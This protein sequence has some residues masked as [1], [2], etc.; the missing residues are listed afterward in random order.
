MRLRTIAPLRRSCTSRARY[1][2]EP[3]EERT[4]LATFVVTRADVDGVNGSLR[5]AILDAN[6]NPGPDVIRFN[7]PGGGVHTIQT[8]RQL[9][10][11]TSPVEVDGTSQPGWA[12][13]HPVIELDGSL[14]S[15]GHGLEVKV[16]GNTV[17]G[18]IIHNYPWHGMVFVEA[19]SLNPLGHNVIQGNFIGT[20]ATGAVARGNGFH[21]LLFIDS[22]SNT[23]GGTVVGDGNLISGNH[24]SGISFSN[25]ISAGNYIVGNRIGTDISG[26]LPLGNQHDG[27]FFSRQVDTNG[28]GYASGN[29]IGSPRTGP[30][31]VLETGG[32][33]IAGNK[34]NGIYILKGSGN[35]VQNN[36]I[37]V[38]ADG[39][40]IPNGTGAPDA[41]VFDGNGVLIE[42]A[43]S[44]VIG[45]VEPGSG[46]VISG[47]RRNGVQILAAEVNASFNRVVGNLIGTNA[48]GE[49]APLMGNRAN[50][51]EITTTGLEQFVF[52]LGNS[53]GGADVSDGDLDE[54]VLARNVISGNLHYG[55]RVAGRVLST[56]IEGNYVGTNK[57]GEGFVHNGFGGIGVVGG[58][59]GASV[60]SNTQIGSGRPGGGNVLSGNAGFG[61]HIVGSATRTFVFGNRIGTNPR[62]D[63]AL[64]N[65]ID[66]SGVYIDGSSDNVIGGTGEGEGNVIS[67]NEG[68]G[69]TI[70][71]DS[72]NNAIQ[73]SLIGVGADGV[74][75]LPNLHGITIGSVEGGT[76]S[77]TGNW[78]GGTEA[79]VDG[80]E[81]TLGN[82]IAANR[83]NG[84]RILA[85]V[86][87]TQ[88]IGNAIGTNF[89]S[90]VLGNTDIGVLI[91]RSGLNTVGGDTSVAG[92]LIAY[93]GVAGVVVSGAD[94][95][96]NKLFGNGIA[97]NG[98]RE[99][100]TG[101]SG[102]RI[103]SGAGFTTVDGNRIR[104]NRGDGV[105]ISRGS[106]NTLTRN[107]IGTEEDG[108]AGYGVLIDESP[109]N[110]IGDI[111]TVDGTTTFLGNSISGN[112]KV[113]V[114]INGE[115]STGNRVFGNVITS[116]GDFGIDL[117]LGPSSTTVNQ[118]QVYN[119][120]SGG[121]LINESGPNTLTNN[122][123][124]T[125]S[126]GAEA[127]PNDGPGVWIVSSPGIV[128]GGADY[129]HG[130]NLIS[131]NKSIGIVV[132]GGKTIGTVITGNYIGVDSTATKPLGNQDG[133]GIGGSEAVGGAA[134]LTTVQ[135][136][137]I[138]GNRENGVS[139]VAGASANHLL[140]NF[141]GTNADDQKGLGNSGYGVLIKGSPLN[142]VGG[143]N[144]TDGNDIAYNGTPGATELSAGVRI[145]GAASVGNGL[146]GNTI[147]DNEL[148]AVDITEGAS[149]TVLDGNAIYRNN[150]PG[151]F[152][153]E[154]GENNRLINNLI[155]TDFEGLKALP[156]TKQGVNVLDTPGTIIGSASFE[157][158]NVISGNDAAGI[159]LQGKLTTGTR[160][161]GNIIGLDANNE[162]DLPNDQGIIVGG[163]TADVAAG[164][165]VIQNNVIAGNRSQGVLITA[166]STGN[167]IGGTKADEENLIHGNGGLGIDLGDDGVTPNDGRKDKD[168]GSNDLQNYPE[169]TFAT[170]NGSHRVAGKLESDPGTKYVLELF[171]NSEA[172]PSKFGEGVR[173]LARTEVTT[174]ASGIA[175][176]DITLPATE[177]PDS[178]VTATATN[179][180]RGNT[181]EFSKAVRIQIDSDGDGVP[182]AVENA[183]PHAGDFNQDGVKDGLQNKAAT[184]PTATTNE[185]IL[186]QLGS[187]VLG[188]PAQ[189]GQVLSNVRPLPNPSPDD[190][191]SGV[192]FHLG[193]FDFSITGL[194]LGG[195]TM[196]EV[197]LPPGWE[198]SS[199]YRYGPT[200]DQPAPHWYDWSFDGNT[201]AQLFGN[202][203]VLRFVDGQR[204]DDDLVANGTIVD[205]G[206]A[207]FA[208]PIVVTN[209]LDSG[210]G[211]L[212]RAIEDAN[213]R[214]GR[215]FIGFD[216]GTG[217]QTI[218]TLSN[219]PGIT[220]PVFIDGTSQP[221][222]NG[223]P[224]IEINGERVPQ[225]TGLTISAPFTTVRGLVI[226]RFVDTFSGGGIGIDVAVPFN[227]QSGVV[228][229]GNFIG[230]DVT[231]MLRRQN[232]AG[233]VVRGGSD[234]RIGGTTPESR[235]VVSGNIDNGIEILGGSGHRVQGNFV[236]VAANGVSP[237]E[238]LEN[239]VFVGDTFRVTIG[240]LDQAAGNVIAFNRGA[241][242][243]NP[244]ARGNRR[245]T[246]LSNSIH[247]N[248]LLGIARDIGSAG[249]VI[250]ND[251]GTTDGLLT[252][253][254]NYPVLWSA[255]S[256]DDQT[257]ISGYFNSRPDT[258]FLLQFFSNSAVE[259]SGFG[260]GRT[261][262]GTAMVHTNAT[263]HVDFT[264][265]F[266]GAIARG[267]LVTATSTLSLFETTALG[268]TSEFSRRLV[269]G[270]VLAQVITVNSADDVDDGVADA[271]H[272]SLREAIH[273]ANNFP[274][275]N[276]IRFAIGSGART[277]RPLTP[278][279][280]ITDAVLIDG[281]TQPGFAGSPVIQLTGLGAP[282]ASG[283]R[284]TAS[285][286]T[287]RGL[288]IN[289]FR[290][291]AGIEV[292]EIAAT[293]LGSSLPRVP[294]LHDVVIEGNFIGTSADG[295]SAQI[296]TGGNSATSSGNG[297][298]IFI[299]GGFDHL[300]GGTTPAARNVISANLADGI[301][302]SSGTRYQVKGSLIGVAA[303]GVS[304]LGNGANGV[305]IGIQTSGPNFDTRV[306]QST[307]GGL[308]SGAGNVIAFNAFHGVQNRQSTRGIAV[309]SNSIH[310]NALMGV[311]AGGIRSIGYPLS[312][313]VTL[314]DSGLTDGTDNPQNYP[315]L[316]SAQ[317][318]GDQTTISGSLISR[319]NATFV[320]QF[321]SNTSVEVSGFGEGET[322]LGSET[323]T[324]GAAGHV[325]FSAVLPVAVA[326]RRVITATATG[327][328]NNT[329]EFSR[330]LAVGD[331]LSGVYTVNTTD[332]VD[333]GT[334]DATHTSLREAIHA[335]NNHPGPD[336]I[337]FAIGSGVRT[338]SPLT[339]LPAIVDPQTSI[340]GT[341]QPGYA[342]APVIELNGTLMERGRYDRPS[343]TEFYMTGLSIRTDE[344]TIRGLVMNR[345]FE[346]TL[347][348]AAVVE[349]GGIALDVAGNRNVIEGN[350]IGT[351]VAGGGLT[352]TGTGGSTVGNRNILIPVTVI[353]ANNRV[354]GTTPQQRNVISGH[355]DVGLKVG[356]T[357]NLIQG[358]YIGTNAA[359]TAAIGNGRGTLFD[360]VGVIAGGEG[361]MIGGAAPGAGN[362]ISG[363]SGHGLRAGVGSVV[364]GN[365][366]GTNAAGTARLGNTGD[367]I[368]IDDIVARPPGV[369][370]VVVGG[371]LPGERNVISGN[372]NGIFIASESFNLIQGNY[373]GT[374]VTGIADL[375]NSSD[376]IVIARGVRQQIGG[377]APGAGNLISGNDRFGILVA[378]PNTGPGH[379]IQGNRVGTQANGTSALG[380]S[381]DGIMFA[382]DLNLST[383]GTGPS[384]CIV[385]GTEEGA[386][387]VIA[388]NGRH[389]VNILAGSRIGIL[390]NSIHSN[391][392]L[393]IDLNSNGVTANDVG[394]ADAGENELQNYPVLTGAVTDGVRT[395]VTGTLN[396]TPRAGFLL[397]FFSN[398][399]AEPSGFG[400]GRTLLGTRTVFTDAS[401][402]AN[403]TLI[404]PVAVTVGQF[405]S[406]T[407][408]DPANNTSEFARSVQVPGGEVGPNVAPSADA[409]GPYF[410][411]EGG[412][413]NLSAVF[414]LDAD[415]DPLSYAWDVNGDG[416]F[417]DAAGVSPTL[418]WAQL[419]ALGVVDG[420]GSFTI[421]V[422]VDDGQDHVV[423]SEPTQLTIRNAAPVVTAGPSDPVFETDMIRLTGSFTDPG[424]LDTHTMRWSV[425]A[426]N[427]QVIADGTG[428][429][430][431]FLTV[432]SG[433]YAVT[434]T[435]TDS[436]GGVG[437]YT[438]NVL[439]FNVA[440]FGPILG[441]PAQGRVGTPLELFVSPTDPSPV[442]TAAGFE[443]A[444]FVYFGNDVLAE[445][446][447][448][449]F[450]F[451]PTVP[452]EYEIE[453][454]IYDK[455][456]HNSRQNVRLL[457]VDAPATMA[458]IV[459]LGPDAA[460]D[461]GSAYTAAG[462]FA[463]ADPG[464]A[465]TA[466][467]DYGDDSGV[468]SLELRPDKTFDLSHV[469]AD[470]GVYD[471]VVRVTD[472]AGLVGSDT[473]RVTVRNVA[474]VVALDEPQA[475]VVGTALTLDGSFA[476]PGVDDWS[477]TVNYGD[478]SG[479]RPLTLGAGGTFSLDH[480]Y[481]AGGEFTV[482]VTVVD[483]DGG[484]GT[485]ARTAAVAKRATSL[486]SPAGGG[487]YGGTTVLTATL[488]VGGVPLSGKVVTFTLG[489]LNVGSSVT[490]SSGEAELG[491]VSLGA[492]DAGSV[493]LTVSFVGD[494]RHVSASA[495]TTFVIAKAQLTVVVDDKTRV[496]GQDNPLL[497]GTIVGVTNGDAI[498]AT[499][500]S[501]AV[502]T[503]Q[504]GA[505]PVTPVLHDPDGRLRNYDVNVD[506][507]TLTVLAAT[508][509]ETRR[510]VTGTAGVALSVVVASFVTDNPIAA[511]GDFT[512]TIDWGDGSVSA[513]AVR[514][515]GDG[516][517]VVGDKT[518][519]SGGDY[520]ITVS[521]R[522]NA[523]G[524]STTTASR[525][526]IVDAVNVAP[527]VTIDSPQP[528][529][530]YS[531][532]TVVPLVGS[533]V[534]PDAGDTHTAFWTI[535]IPGSVPVV[536]Q[537]GVSGGSVTGSY[538]FTGAGVYQVTLT[539]TDSRGATGRAATTGD[540]GVV[541][542]DPAAG[543]V[544]G[545]GW[546]QSPAGASANPA[547]TG[548]AN[549]GFN[550]QY[551][552]D[553]SIPTGQFE[554]RVGRLNFHSTAFQALVITGSRARLHG[555]GT[556]NGR[557]GYS[558]VLTFVDGSRAGGTDRI[559][560]R[561]W[562]STSG[563]V[564]YD[565]GAGH[566]EDDGLTPLLGGNTRIVG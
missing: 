475:V 152:I 271:T 291:A 345:F 521:I 426:A 555:A 35:T 233:I 496:Y 127:K 321:F 114:R 536:V 250:L 150:G 139:I 485:A 56:T 421:C 324:T 49:F 373:I 7:I 12:P 549:F 130:G 256:T 65:G 371:A 124:G 8:T 353:G 501:A 522:D 173:F 436:D 438:V 61:V 190:A 534:D 457:V 66:A 167:R 392:Q 382:A 362:V 403:F 136:N 95:A 229:E 416:T 465:W 313:V 316:A 343:A 36:Y 220:D 4:L 239:G 339:P 102:V 177:G 27:I 344:T 120:K 288:V 417:G 176:F 380:N 26:T 325:D 153:G 180:T 260:Q 322:Y 237:L 145:E 400:E 479:D 101:K 211:S 372:R 9:P 289:A 526:A 219:L 73:N 111:K 480:T 208:P 293:L 527:V 70:V 327:S 218:T 419:Q 348:G 268:D 471:V 168:S 310:D 14:M 299:G 529:S 183:G 448:R 165:T 74:R 253:V 303:D 383:N 411:D 530:V 133:I 88:V 334:A 28:V 1:H 215:D 244:A 379:V 523:G 172:D 342:G 506:E 276:T 562:N 469:Y 476:D 264:A 454:F 395:S 515:A 452:G 410:I 306:T 499:Y 366:I 311:T 553:A 308:E 391:G 497:T 214:L 390:S 94:A 358:N 204:G 178:Y 389:G 269:V 554:F 352:A 222:F 243:L 241:G 482:T 357:G 266:P 453:L 209:T 393:G 494:T 335:A 98:L 121:V 370:G 273:A 249:N 44:N 76:S 489:G 129:K 329:S 533:L 106:S 187:S 461:E 295:L 47:N 60:P 377:T 104:G 447:E 360:G 125:D 107:A 483:D 164:K 213:A 270:D 275:P 309:L 440:P 525:A 376:G 431:E 22:P 378:V 191:P 323:V 312:A 484:T 54:R 252:N 369:V 203:V 540:A 118:N 16:G 456:L 556:V 284:V 62:G 89:K 548:R 320:L 495:A 155:G 331:V 508:L 228:I 45:G 193:F 2:A 85:G 147:R 240:G 401:G 116:N 418:L 428:T 493:P 236:G 330:R 97:F 298:G 422:R 17:K 314:N 564:L 13:D 90:D 503:S 160:I 504:V 304:P 246:I 363:N 141:I 242:I 83:S 192:A 458:P 432:D 514:G 198:A 170:S 446:A 140:N 93:N 175:F 294:Y 566:A 543:M 166:G 58:T 31:T 462:S 186:L 307:I 280:V 287:V 346:I 151:V 223:T 25:A 361:T 39:S 404:F 122:Y 55:I 464:D 134:R 225:G 560:V 384:D 491:D 474:P 75:K 257:T 559:R 230:T 258:D 302:L 398:P 182:D 490:D 81:A 551:Q 368:V 117:E 558:F 100:A 199:F 355:Y 427:G 502:N 80:T 297:Y 439:A 481:D 292:Y 235:N 272:T 265:T 197:R 375:G 542:Y 520:S 161:T 399:I 279:P 216:I 301:V 433:N 538:V 415:G 283:L 413:L 487:T 539:V 169:I 43:E 221:G 414:S 132:S 67:G 441:L 158:G 531:V 435:V 546:F 179:D 424:T 5:D 72:R 351:T 78:I 37:G 519:A 196:A 328:D 561:I 126:V 509:A 402:N 466:T 315:V 33:I 367:G 109:G 148:V 159:V 381:S 84:I 210:P 267:Q 423:T 359:G 6:L 338:I 524:G 50:G 135:N 500:A 174:N 52:A 408:T 430:F 34:L 394:D 463:D 146:I 563:T 317:S 3:L 91:D 105:S 251:P 24:F 517:E 406:A 337:R 340:D 46:N 318:S 319:P 194:T 305:F 364:Q 277:I 513:G 425:E 281:T 262:L 535:N 227:F 184:F 15:E 420:P 11:I 103:Q 356:G 397:Q 449:E 131:G 505:Y 512:V 195:G 82:V 137:V 333:D 510:N 53:I 231:G 51:V 247:S 10:A 29:F 217:V 99:D 565:S 234:H 77:P 163:R 156:N 296:S 498:T 557:S 69:V 450:S 149:L 57:S 473:V 226:N 300:I 365:F 437:T 162:E 68:S 64:P 207:G 232:R 518:Y 92:N 201:G 32:N 290:Q 547:Y 255:Q 550:A 71:G 110:V 386:G 108:N 429:T 385:G 472:G 507:G 468:Q 332:D 451:T 455:D 387:N 41:N 42:S 445:G 537:G 113:G 112:E 545:G 286:T 200:P 87:F 486:A 115:A 142:V 206:G 396:S 405:V 388:F 20:D 278:L 274:G 205:P 59:G 18:L 460:I 261:L 185:P 181:S 349:A 285:N 143:T 248:A 123:I 541:V 444:W 467:V 350:Y 254:I 532:G 245:I 442:D 212:R 492:F 171:A 326:N 188:F 157:D 38:G 282:N 263:G 189:P 511:A 23:I 412:A 259:I 86:T 144:D 443:Y 478:G 347:N 128:V 374:N 19:G 21:G 79:V 154:A 488:T 470:D 341:T 409:G 544:T 477:A 202:V 63:A 48:D 336:L 459:T 96:G 224:I 138:A 119:N 238:N 30:G 407:A 434:F 516:F 40:S 528:G 552:Q 354:G